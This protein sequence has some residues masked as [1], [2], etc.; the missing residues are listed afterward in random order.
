MPVSGH[1][2]LSLCPPSSSALLVLPCPGLANRVSRRFLRALPAFFPFLSSFPWSPVPSVSTPTRRLPLVHTGSHLQCWRALAVIKP[3]VA[4]V[5]QCETTLYPP[6][7]MPN[8]LARGHSRSSHASST[9]KAPRSQMS[10]PAECNAELLPMPLCQISGP[11]QQLRLCLLPRLALDGSMHCLHHHHR[12]VFC[13]L[14]TQTAMPCAAT[15]MAK[16]GACCI[17]TT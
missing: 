3:W 8:P 15:C 14:I 16:G 5:S 10:E 7:P 4:L 17:I 9:A 1:S 12:P 6:F 13:P 11:T 2:L